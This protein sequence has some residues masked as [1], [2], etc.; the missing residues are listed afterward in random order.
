MYWICET[1]QQAEDGTDLMQS[2][3]DWMQWLYKSRARVPPTGISEWHRNRI[4]ILN[5]KIWGRLIENY[6]RRSLTLPTD[7]L[8]AIGALASSTEFLLP[9]ITSLDVGIQLFD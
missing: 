2:I 6:S 1:I 5:H 7:K 4:D 9:Q 3:P 8:A